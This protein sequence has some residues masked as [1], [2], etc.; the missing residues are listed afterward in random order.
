MFHCMLTP[1][2]VYGLTGEYLRHFHLLASANN[3]AVTTGLPFF[4]F[5]SLN[6]CFY[7]QGDGIA[8]SCGNLVSLLEEPPG[9]FSNVSYRKAVS[10]K[11]YPLGT[12]L[13]YRTLSSFTVRAIRSILVVTKL[14]S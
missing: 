3:A 1:H 5:F 9:G 11:G 12:A 10:S 14:D 7:S 6:V 2:F 13:L 4:V 8:E